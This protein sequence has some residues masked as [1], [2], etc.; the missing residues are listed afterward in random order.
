MGFDLF[1]K[2]KSDEKDLVL[3]IFTQDVGCFLESHFGSY[4]IFSVFHRTKSSEY[5]AHF[6]GDGNFLKRLLMNTMKSVGDMTPC[7][8]PCLRSILL[9]FVLYM[10]TLA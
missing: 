4:C 10:T 6:T 1:D 9:L 3:F 2:V 5:M 8:T 7:G